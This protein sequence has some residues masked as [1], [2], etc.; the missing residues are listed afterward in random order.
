LRKLVTTDGLIVDLRKNGGGILE[1]ALT[2]S[3][4]LLEKACLMTLHW[5]GKGGAVKREY[6]LHGN[7]LEAM[8]TS[9]TGIRR[10]KWR[11]RHEAIVAG[12]PMVVLIDEGTGS[13][14]ELLACV[15][16]DN[17]DFYGYICITI[18]QPTASKGITQ[19]RH[20][21]TR[22]VTLR[23]SVNRYTS[24]KDVWFGDAGQFVSNPIVP[25]VFLDFEAVESPVASAAE[26]LLNAIHSSK[27]QG[28]STV[29]AA[30]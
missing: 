30:S 5:T 4:F 1:Q 23:I 6:Y 2:C 12:K 28:L 19:E 29:R 14:A 27:T 15:L 26:I 8:Q 21:I 24:P 7:H 17:A 3:Q 9:S 20:K 25:D 13:S 11:P 18:G 22:S 16:R 10:S